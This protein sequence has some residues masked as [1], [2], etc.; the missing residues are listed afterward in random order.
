MARRYGRK[1]DPTLS[2]LIMI[3]D[4]AASD[5]RLTTFADTLSIYQDNLTF[6]D[7]GRPEAN[8][9]YSAPGSTGFTVLI[10]DNNEDTHLILTPNTA[11]ADGA[12]TL[13][14]NTNA[15]DKQQVSL[16]CTQQVT[17]FVINPNGASAVTG[18]IT[19]LGVDD[20]FTLQYDK[21]LNTWYQIG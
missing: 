18:G 2:D 11:Y 9:Q 17:N 1:T 12:I 7:A 19:A 6:P 5:W 10:N 4:S 15:R 20:Y 8:T 16:N 14:L 3:W 21:T 13:P